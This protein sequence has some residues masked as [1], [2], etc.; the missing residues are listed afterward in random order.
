MSLDY[1]TLDLK[2]NVKTEKFEVKGDVN[3]TGQRE[4]VENFLRGQIGAGIDESKPNRQSEYSIILNWHPA[5]DT[6]KVSSDT[7]NKGLRDG[8]L[9]Q[10][11]STL[12]V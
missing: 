1:L 11:L 5:D 7:G 3:I 10:F 4:L 12:D 8:I 6:I 9:M 2:Y